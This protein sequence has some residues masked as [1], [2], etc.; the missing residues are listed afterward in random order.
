ML[1]V[2]FFLRWKEQRLNE[3]K[4]ILKKIDKDMK[5]FARYWHAF[6]S[7]HLSKRSALHNCPDNEKNS[8]TD[9]DSKSGVKSN[10]YMSFLG[11]RRS[12]ICSWEVQRV[13]DKNGLMSGWQ[14]SCIFSDERAQKY[15]NPFQQWT[16]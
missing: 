7:L 3:V 8:L 4:S 13:K 5:M 16:R 9:F 14:E 6:F 12:T 10:T 2:H 11:W 15:L 1:S